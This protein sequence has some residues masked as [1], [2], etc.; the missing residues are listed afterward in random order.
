MRVEARRALDDFIR[1]TEK[2]A[3]AGCMLFWSYEAACDTAF[4]LLRRAPASERATLTK[5]AELAVRVMEQFASI[6][7]VG[8]CEAERARGRWLALAGKTR[9][10]EKLLGAAIESARAFD[11]PVE[12]GKA[13]ADLSRIARDPGKR[14]EHARAAREVF[15]RVGTWGL[16]EEIDEE[17]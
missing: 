4:L 9:E 14:R 1:L 15:T 7:P 11:L 16:L 10:A 2:R 13:H 17:G 12:T 3:P 6:F 8:R 5:Q